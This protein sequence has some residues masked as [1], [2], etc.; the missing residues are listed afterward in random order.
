M[1][2]KFKNQLAFLFFTTSNEKKSVQM[3]HKQYNILRH[4]VSKFASYFLQNVQKRDKTCKLFLAT[5]LIL[6]RWAG[7]T[8][9]KKV[10]PPHTPPKP[11]PAYTSVVLEYIGFYATKLESISILYL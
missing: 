2:S 4:P 3:Y 11:H 7:P 1:I 5:N 6:E 8:K 10:Y 9:G